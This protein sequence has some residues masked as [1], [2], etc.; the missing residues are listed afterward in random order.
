MTGSL[1]LDPEMNLA[2]S[3]G[4][5]VILSRLLLNPDPKPTSIVMNISWGLEAI[6]GA[7]VIGDSELQA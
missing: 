6:V 2:S 7:G 4:G 3:L 1:V 5:S